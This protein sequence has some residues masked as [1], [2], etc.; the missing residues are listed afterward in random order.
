[1]L[2]SESEG[3]ADVQEAAS[4]RNRQ[5]GRSLAQKLEQCSGDRFIG[6]ILAKNCPLNRTRK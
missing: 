3:L 1:V 6:A 5:G 2:L 4:A